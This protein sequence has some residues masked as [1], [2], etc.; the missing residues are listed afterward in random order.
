MHILKDT[1]DMLHEAGLIERKSLHKVSVHYITWWTY[2][3]AS[4]K[5]TTTSHLAQAAAFQK[6]WDHCWIRSKA[7]HAFFRVR[8]NYAL[9]DR[10]RHH[11]RHKRTMYPLVSSLFLNI[12]SRSRGLSAN[13]ATLSIQ[14]RFYYTFSDI[15]LPPACMLFRL[16]M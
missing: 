7:P 15:F 16:R 12:L 5:T 2:E 14:Q 4:A 6:R 1:L 13:I 8:E 3:S 11:Y 10:V 9:S